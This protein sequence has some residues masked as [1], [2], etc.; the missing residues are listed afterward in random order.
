[1]SDINSLVS[2]VAEAAGKPQDKYPV[3]KKLSEEESL[4]MV[5][6]HSQTHLSIVTGKIGKIVHDADHSGSIKENIEKL[7]EELFS[8]IF[9]ICVF[10]DTLEMS[11]EELLNGTVGLAR[12]I[13]KGS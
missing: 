12:S 6:G 8:A 3:S 5:L 9:T 13:L 7:K 1:M 10:A 2:L 11:G 4:I